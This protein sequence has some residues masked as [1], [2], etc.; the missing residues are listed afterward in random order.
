MDQFVA[1]IIVTSEAILLGHFFP[2]ESF[3]FLNCGLSLL[4]IAIN[5]AF[6]VK[7]VVVF[8]FEKDE[9]FCLF[10]SVVDLDG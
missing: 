7:L 9:E 1:K 6:W 2:Q 10:F 4:E 3:I 8:L 5:V